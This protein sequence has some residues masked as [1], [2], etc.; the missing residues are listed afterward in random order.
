MFRALA[1]QAADCDGSMEAQCQGA[2]ILDAAMDKPAGVTFL[3]AYLAVISVK[4]A[5]G[6]AAVITTTNQSTGGFK[7]IAS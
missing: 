6:P 5:Y 3:L 1:A 7:P 2:H 4:D